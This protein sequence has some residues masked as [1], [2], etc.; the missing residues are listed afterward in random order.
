MTPEEL[1]EC[2]WHLL[3]RAEY[4]SRY[5]RRRAAFLTN[6]DTLFTLITITAGASA[7]GDLVGGSPGWLAKAG[8]AVVTLISLVQAILRLGSAGM[9]HVQWLKRWSRLQTEI[10]LNTD[11]D[12]ADI[13]GWMTEK[14]SIE[15]DCVTELRALVLDCEDAAARVL[16]IAGRQH[17]IWSLQ[18]LLIHFGTFQQTFPHLADAPSNKGS[19]KPPQT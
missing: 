6:L 15:E 13:K 8:A 5:H 16:G 19:P 17:R 14:A 11:P 2:R 10:T 9:T 4:S 12:E 3:Y 7:F 1:E 18:R